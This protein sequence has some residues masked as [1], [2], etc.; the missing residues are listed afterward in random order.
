MVICGRAQGDEIL[1][2]LTPTLLAQVT[3]DD[4]WLLIPALPQQTSIPPVSI[5]DHISCAF[6][7]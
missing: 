5:G 4:A 3:Q 2:L 6:R 7:W 1:S